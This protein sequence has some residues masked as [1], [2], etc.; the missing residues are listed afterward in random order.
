MSVYDFY[1]FIFTERHKEKNPFKLQYFITVYGTFSI[2][3][4]FKSTTHDVLSVDC[5]Q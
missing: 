5:Q 3:G 4:G 1:L 2:N